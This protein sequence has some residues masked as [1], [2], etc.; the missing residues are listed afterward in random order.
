MN[1]SGPRTRKRA[2][3]NAKLK[4]RSVKLGIFSCELRLP[5]CM[6]NQF[7]SWAHSKKSRFLV[8]DEDWMEAV[9]SCQS[10]HARIEGSGHEPMKRAVLDAIARR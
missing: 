6:G 7:L 9:L 4:A 8:T 5:G 10:C 2:A 3:M 1:R